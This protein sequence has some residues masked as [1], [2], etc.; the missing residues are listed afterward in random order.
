MLRWL[1]I[2]S[3]V[4]CSHDPIIIIYVFP[5]PPQVEGFFPQNKF[6]KIAIVIIIVP[7]VVNVSGHHSYCMYCMHYILD[8]NFSL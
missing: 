3:T 8:W 6:I 2:V 7:L 5:H 4:L 1:F